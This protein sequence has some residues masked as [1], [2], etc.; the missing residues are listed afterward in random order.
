MCS[1]LGRRVHQAQQ[2]LQEK[3][4]LLSQAEEAKGPSRRRLQRISQDLRCEICRRCSSDAVVGAEY[5]MI[6]LRR[7]R[8]HSSGWMFLFEIGCVLSLLPILLCSCTSQ[9]ALLIARFLITVGVLC[10]SASGRVQDRVHLSLRLP[11]LRIDGGFIPKHAAFTLRYKTQ[12][13]CASCSC[14]TNIS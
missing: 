8:K 9:P 7:N 4:I 5:R 2:C 12:T 1:A 10:C 13:A 11:A 14:T 6:H 3:G